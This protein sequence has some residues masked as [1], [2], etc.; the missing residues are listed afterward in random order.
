MS[1]GLAKVR[2]FLK[3]LVNY[4]RQCLQLLLQGLVGGRMARKAMDYLEGLGRRFVSAV[5][6]RRRIHS[7]GQWGRLGLC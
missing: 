2:F 7:T 6:E 4:C 3:V 1:K 5:I